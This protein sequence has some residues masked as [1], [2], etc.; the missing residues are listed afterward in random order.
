VSEFDQF[1]KQFSKDE[2]SDAYVNGLNDTLEGRPVAAYMAMYR[3]R[4]AWEAAHLLAEGFTKL[5]EVMPKRVFTA[6]EIVGIINADVALYEFM[7]T[8]QG[9]GPLAAEVPEHAI[10]T[11]AREAGA[12]GV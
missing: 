9:R 10:W 5:A 11:E 7:V 12:E 2:Q 8:H 6:D 4:I 1:E 3:A